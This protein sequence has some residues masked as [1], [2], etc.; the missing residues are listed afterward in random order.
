[1]DHG[2]S[3]FGGLIVGVIGIINLIALAQVIGKAGYS[4]WW[5][6][7]T[8]VP[9]ANILALWK[10]GFTEWPLERLARQDR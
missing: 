9:I 10:F 3:V 2:M 5:V 4:R 1:M 6:L 7:I 8:F